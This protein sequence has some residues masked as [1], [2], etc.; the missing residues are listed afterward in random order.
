MGNFDAA[1]FMQQTS[2]EKMASEP[3]LVPPGEYEAVVDKLTAKAPRNN[4]SGVN[5]AITW[6]IL[7]DELKTAL[8]RPKITVMQFLFVEL[9]EA[10]KIATGGDKN[11]RLGQVREAVKQD[12]GPWH[13]AML[14]G[15]G[16]ALVRVS[17][18]DYEGNTSARVD[19]VVSIS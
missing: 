1:A 16:P 7:S 9:D 18:S 11:W 13:P 17:H 3:V 15:A 12:T 19:R 6:E 5:L 4:D 2:E 10:G 14:E 8:G